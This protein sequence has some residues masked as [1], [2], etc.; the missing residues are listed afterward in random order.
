MIKWLSCDVEIQHLA[1]L[2]LL[3][4]PNS[5][6]T[7]AESVKINVIVRDQKKQRGFIQSG[8]RLYKYN[9]KSAAK[10]LRY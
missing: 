8:N 9:G 5:P 4:I 10:L 1:L 3:G 6:F 2:K 7:K